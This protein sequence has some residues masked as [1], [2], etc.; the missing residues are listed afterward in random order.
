MEKTVKQY[1]HILILLGMMVI[2]LLDKT[3]FFYPYGIFVRY[4]A[5]I[6]YIFYLIYC[7]RS[8]IVRFKSPINKLKNFPPIYRILSDITLI[9]CVFYILIFI[10]CGIND[11][12]QI[13]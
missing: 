2:M 11:L 8:I 6:I 12:S 5:P 9:L 1:L 3:I 13:L 10:Y 7:F 4:L